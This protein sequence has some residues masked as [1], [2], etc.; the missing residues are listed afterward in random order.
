MVFP[1][2]CA[3][4]LKHVPAQSRA[5]WDYTLREVEAV[6]KGA[7]FLFQHR[8]RRH[9]FAWRIGGCCRLSAIRKNACF[10]IYSEMGSGFGLSRCP[11]SPNFLMWPPDGCAKRICRSSPRPMQPHN[12][13]ES[14]FEYIVIVPA[15]LILSENSTV[16]EASRAH[17]EAIAEGYTDAVIM[18]R[19]KDKWRLYK[20]GR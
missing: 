4:R 13:I 17:K 14:L 16:E 5:D 2:C 6:S 8:T 18:K 19:E 10:A 20:R 1:A 12:P 9:V 15:C 7:A 11:S 3:H